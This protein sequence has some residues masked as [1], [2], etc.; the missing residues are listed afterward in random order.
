MITND[1]AG[2]AAPSPEGAAADA[3]GDVP[4]A[5]IGWLRAIASG[6]AVLIV[7]F[8]AAV[9]GAN[10]IL[11]NGLGLHG[12]DQRVWS[13]TALFLVVVGLAAWTLRRLQARGLI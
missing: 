13:A 8:G 9:G 4:Q 3:A 10:L 1:P 2:A 11:T 5:R 6:L 7:G 12:R